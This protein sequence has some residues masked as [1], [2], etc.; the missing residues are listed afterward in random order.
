MLDDSINLL[1]ELD[2]VSKIHILERDDI[3]ALMLEFARRVVA[4]LRIERVNVW[5]FNQERDA[6]V[7]IGE[8]DLRTHQYSK[9]TTLYAKDFPAYFKAIE[10][11]KIILAPNIYTHPSTFQFNE[12]YSRPNDIISLMDIPFRIEGK[13]VGVICF[14]KIGD[15]ERVF[16]EKEQTFAL[17]VSLVLASNL[18]ARHRRAAQYRLDHLLKEKDLLLQEINHRVK[19]NFSILISLLRLSRQGKTTDPKTILEEYEQR[20][21]SMLKIQEM[22][23]QTQKYTS[24][25][26]NQYI[27]ALLNEFK[28]SY[29]EIA[30]SV[31]QY[32]EDSDCELPSKMA[33]HLGLI[34][35]EIMLNS[36]K[37]AYRK[38]KNYELHLSLNEDS[39]HTVR[40]KIG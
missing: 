35:T 27:S 13:L 26:L 8:Y 9:N 7:S 16:S 29:S 19:N 22:L 5:L 1:E 2:N 31:K 11:N 30:P 34:V 25:N 20:I 28:T 21:F 6:I 10:E 33:I 37:R 38:T 36:Y 17:S 15:K 40:L 14:E 39:K 18:E 23:Y 12:I 3:D 4:I 24:I 32:I